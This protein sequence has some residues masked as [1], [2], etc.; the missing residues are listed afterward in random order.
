[1]V[2]LNVQGRSRA[3]QAEGAHFQAIVQRTPQDRSEH[4]RQLQSKGARG[5]RELPLLLRKASS[6]IQEG[7]QHLGHRKPPASTS[8]GGSSPDRRVDCVMSVELGIVGS[9]KAR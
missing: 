6:S 2:L 7:D 8:R 5:V 9:N 1:M 3:G 4:V